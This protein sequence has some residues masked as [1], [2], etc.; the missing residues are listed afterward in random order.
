MT[1]TATVTDR[2][3]AVAIRRN[4]KDWEEITPALEE[5][6]APAGDQQFKVLSIDF[7]GRNLAGFDAFRLIDCRGD[8]NPRL[9]E[10]DVLTE[11]EK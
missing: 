7:V 6:P 8:Y 9:V 1:A 2:L 11:A 5:K 10:L 3:H 4:G